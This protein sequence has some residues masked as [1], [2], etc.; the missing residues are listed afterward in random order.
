M[1]RIST[2]SQDASVAKNDK[3]IGSDAGGDTRNFTLES[4]ADFLN[5]SSLI[6]VNGQ[7]IYKFETATDPDNGEFTFVGLANFANIVFAQDWSFTSSL[8][9]YFT[10][11]LCPTC[12]EFQLLMFVF[13]FFIFTPPLY[14]EL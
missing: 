4:I 1:A 8:S 2:Y 7:L 14:G 3:L 12:K 9:F 11:I 6:N 10:L 13:K 5:T